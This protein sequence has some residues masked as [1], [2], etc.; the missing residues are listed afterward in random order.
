MELIRCVTVEHLANAAFLICGGR[1][2]ILVDAVF[3]RRFLP[4]S[5][6]P[7]AL[8]ESILRAQG[9]FA[10]VDLFLF[11]HCHPDHCDPDDVLRLQKSD[12]RL[13]LPADAYLD[14]PQRPRQDTIPLDG[15]GAVWEDDTLR[16]TAVETE[17]DR[18]DD[19]SR[20]M[21]FS[22]LLDFKEEDVCILVMGDA[23][24]APGLFEKWL[25]GRH[26]CAATVNFVEINQIKGRAF[27]R[28]ISPEFALLCHLP[29][30]EDDTYHMGRLTHKNIDKYRDELPPCVICYEPRT[31]LELQRR[32]NLP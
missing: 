7:P 1:H 23:A 13:I 16:V 26:L 15:S 20:Q 17:H 28:E 3:S 5:A 18:K 10:D 31:K 6:M 32:K 29:L 14:R 8:L 25:C 9:A 2:T 12:T 11:T 24:T 19:V 22:Y 30:P 4:F 21:H 27:L